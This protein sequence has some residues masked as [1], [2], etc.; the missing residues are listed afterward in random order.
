MRCAEVTRELGVP[1]A[2]GDPAALARHL[3]SCDRCATRAEAVRRFDTLWNATRPVEPSAAAWERLWAN[4]TLTPREAPD[5]V[6]FPAPGSR[7]RWLAPVVSLA[8]VAQAAALLIAVGM[9]LRRNE[10]RA[11]SPAPIVAQV[12]QVPGQVI[13]FELEADQTLFLELDESGDRVVCRPKFVPTYE[14]VAFDPEGLPP[15]DLAFQADL[16][17]LN[18]F[19][20]M[21]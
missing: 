10:I 17:M 2:G 3:A 14:L 8:L 13:E 11:N 6:P 5:T 1:T 9:L 16:A 15:V 12:A 19:E 21:E 18:H 4:V 20:G 7:R